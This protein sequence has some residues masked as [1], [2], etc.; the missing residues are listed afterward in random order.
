LIILA[1][2]G[3]RK[4]DNPRLPDFTR[5]PQPQITKEAGSD[6]VISSVTP[7]AFAGKIAVDVYFKNDVKPAKFDVVVIKNGDRKNVKVIQA[8]V[9]AFPTSV[10]VT[11]A[12]LASL[13]SAPLVLG[14]KF[15][16][17]ADVFTSDG[18]KYPA[19]PAVGESYGTGV[20]TQGGSSLTIRYE[21]VCPFIAADFDGNF[22]VTKDDWNDFGVG[23]V[24][25]VTVVSA[26]KLSFPSPVN[27]LPIVIDVNATTYATSVASQSYGDYKA[28][29]IDP[30]WPYGN[31]FV[32]SVAGPLNVVGACDKTISLS[33]K[34]V[35]NN[36]AQTYGPYTLV[37]K[38]Q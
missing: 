2:V 19:F 30:T 34:Y 31:N 33:L 23:T 38:K 6:V 26:T 20:P 14:D 22:K 21:V 25:P 12:Q 10:P 27:N 11:G 35:S 32:S 13:F 24:V 1:G 37:L 29:G 7:N 15:D 8:A 16:V 36:G 3:C 28:A 18:A 9:T 4:K 5:V 17:G